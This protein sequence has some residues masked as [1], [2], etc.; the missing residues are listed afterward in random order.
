MLLRWFICSCHPVISFLSDFCK[1]WTLNNLLEHMM[2]V[3]LCAR[4]D[5][6]SDR[7]II[8]AVAKAAS[9]LPQGGPGAAIGEDIL[10]SGDHSDDCGRMNRWNLELRHHRGHQGRGRVSGG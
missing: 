8:L 7:V 2:P 6:A 4:Q 5:N 1:H 10:T 9:V 3:S